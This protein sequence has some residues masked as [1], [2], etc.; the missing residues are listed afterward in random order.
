MIDVLESIE[1]QLT[2]FTKILGYNEIHGKIISALLI[3]EGCLSL[4]ELKKKT[5]Y[6]LSSISV[7]IEILE[8]IGVIKKFKNPGDRKIYVR[9]EGDI[10]EFLRNAI[11]IKLQNEI[12][13]TLEELQKGKESSNAKVKIIITNIEKEFKRIDL[14]IQE[15]AN[16]KI[17]KQQ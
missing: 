6:S 4:D 9:L 17:P 11:L 10:L 14:Y 7:S 13:D 5:R 3:E 1:N 8:I 16:V 15:L 2:S 12:K